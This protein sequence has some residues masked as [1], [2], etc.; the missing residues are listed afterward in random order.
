MRGVFRWELL[1]RVNE[2]VLCNPFA[3]HEDQLRKVSRIS[4]RSGPLVFRFPVF[5][6]LAGYGFR[7]HSGP[8]KE[9]WKFKAAVTEI[10]RAVIGY[11]SC[12][13]WS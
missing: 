6:I 7:G 8:E 10:L 2:L 4:M 3:A 9:A 12:G 5:I 11:G 1:T 13:C